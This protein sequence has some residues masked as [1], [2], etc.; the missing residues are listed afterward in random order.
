MPSV[1]RIQDADR[2]A[3]EMH[4]RFGEAPGSKTLRARKDEASGAQPV[5]AAAGGLSAA[6]A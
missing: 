3:L 4:T 1:C 5:G 2:C 6:A